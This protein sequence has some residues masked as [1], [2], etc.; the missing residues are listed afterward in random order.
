MRG[1]L[2]TVS[3]RGLACEARNERFGLDASSRDN[4]SALAGFFHLHQQYSQKAQANAQKKSNTDAPDKRMDI[5]RTIRMLSVDIVHGVFEPPHRPDATSTTRGCKS[6]GGRD[7]GNRGYNFLRP[8]DF[9]F[10]AF[11]R[12]HRRRRRNL[13]CWLRSD[14]APRAALALPGPPQVSSI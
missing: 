4:P 14:G 9:P 2:N 8:P 1:V 12:T 10:S 11:R 13:C 7:S 3:I 6:H 5:G